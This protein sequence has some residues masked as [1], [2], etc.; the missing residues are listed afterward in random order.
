MTGA[1][2]KEYSRPFLW[3]PR[4]GA[5][6]LDS[7]FSNISAARKRDFLPTAFPMGGRGAAVLAF[8]LPAFLGAFAR[9]WVGLAGV[10]KAS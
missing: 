7:V 10:K 4:G 3:V 2:A 9:S 1:G 6:V 8:L 5:A